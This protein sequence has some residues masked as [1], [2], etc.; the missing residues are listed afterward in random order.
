[1]SS[2][3]DLAQEYFAA[4][5]SDSFDPDAIRQLAAPTLDFYYPMHGQF[6]EVEAVI[7]MLTSFRES[8]PDLNFWMTHDLLESGD[9][10]IA[11]W[12]GGGTHTGK[13]IT[14][15]PFGPNILSATGRTIRFSGTSVLRIVDGKIA[16]DHGQE[17]GI[18]ALLQIGAVVEATQ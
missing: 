15:L 3:T 18:D 12:D 2:N 11:R 14:E 16:E 6:T 17:G 7:T 10:V 13:A 4:V 9:H 8:F 1:M 5:W